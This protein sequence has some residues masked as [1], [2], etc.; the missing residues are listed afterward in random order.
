MKNIKLFENFDEAGY[1]NH[2]MSNHKISKQEAEL[3][4]DLEM[5]NFPP[6]SAPDSDEEFEAFAKDTVGKTLGE[7]AEWRWPENPQEQFDMALTALDL[8]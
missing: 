7:Y 6:G 8:K 3:L 5:D 1:K 2:S 4:F